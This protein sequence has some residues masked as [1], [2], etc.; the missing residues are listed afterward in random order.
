MVWLWLTMWV[1]AYWI[2]WYLLTMSGACTCKRSKFPWFAYDHPTRRRWIFGIVVLLVVGVVV[3]LLWDHYWLCW[4]GWW[5][6]VALAYHEKD[7][8][9]RAMKATGRVVIDTFG[10]LRVQPA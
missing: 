3:G 10:R 6:S 7:K 1:F 8:M 4:W 2:F 9:R 5:E